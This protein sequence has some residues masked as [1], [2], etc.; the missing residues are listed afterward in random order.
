MSNLAAFTKHISYSTA[1]TDAIL[2]PSS[3]LKKQLNLPSTATDDDTWL[4]SAASVARS[5]IERMIA[6]GYA[7][8]LQT[9]QLTLNKF[10]SSELGEI[11]LTFPPYNAISSITYY[12]GNNSSTTLASSDYRVIDPGN[13]HRARMFPAIDKVW[14]VTKSRQDAVVIEFTC[15]STASSNVSPTIGHAVKVL[16]DHWY[17]NRGALIIGTISQELQLGIQALLAADGYGFYA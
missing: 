10:P 3:D 17:E 2:F 13:G 12:D 7:I 14:P 1:I 9:K 4:A 8:R 11:E 15:G 6:G 5:M 16:V